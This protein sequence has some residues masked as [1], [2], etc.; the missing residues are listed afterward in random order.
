MCVVN[1]A[2]YRDLEVVAL[3]A[4]R[5]E[6][7]GKRFVYRTAA[8]FVRVR[9]GLEPRG[10]LQAQDFDLPPAGGGLVIA[11][12][13]VPRSTGQIQA[14]LEDGGV[15]PVE[16]QAAALL[17]QTGRGAEI[18]RAAQRAEQGLRE[19]RVVLAYTSRDLLAGDDSRASLE[20][21]QQVS[22]G[23]V[24]ILKRINVR[25][26]YLVAK[27]GITS[28]DLATRGLGVKRARV[29]GQILPGVPAWRLGEESR[30]P[31]LVYVVFP[32]NVGER[33]AL[34]EVVRIFGS[35]VR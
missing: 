3:A 29:M 14:L 6:A 13:Y 1:A 5:A 4:L 27:G 11:G 8:S 23:L 30:F 33:D 7:L 34:A 26:R 35:P 2:S 25:P 19:E 16:V 10:L 20:I 28:S 15:I 32:G 12:S 22:A 18:A 24:E 9:A 17:D 31:G 21:G